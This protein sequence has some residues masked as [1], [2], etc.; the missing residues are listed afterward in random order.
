MTPKSRRAAMMD[1]KA[2]IETELLFKR[3]ES[4]PVVTDALRGVRLN[5]YPGQFIAIMGPS[6]SGKS[7][8]L[9]VLSGLERPTTGRIWIGGQD[10]WALDDRAQTLLRRRHLGFIFQF[11]NLLNGLTVEDNAA[12][13]LALDGMR[14]SQAREKVRPGLCELGLGGHLAAHPTTLSGGQLQRVAIARALAHQPEVILADEPTGNL[15]SKT[16]AEVV[17]L[18]RRQAADRG[19]AV[20]MVTHDLKAASAADRVMILE[21]GQIVETVENEQPSSRVG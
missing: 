1:E 12:L 16:A 14:W 9:H 8:L 20:V 6:G 2:V 10:V 11:F 3:Y 4:G 18:L 17:S 5:V 19:V 15:D 21:D 13:P 7:T